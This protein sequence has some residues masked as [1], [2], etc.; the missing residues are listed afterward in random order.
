MNYENIYKHYENCFETYGDSPLGVDW[1]NKEDAVKRYEVMLNV[2]KDNNKKV[3]ILDFGCGCGHLLNYIN[4]KELNIEYSGLDIS[5]KF[6][7]YCK[8]KYISNNFYNLDILKENIS[9]LPNFDYII[10]NG[11]FTEKRDLS[12]EYMFSFFSELLKKLYTKINIGLAFNVMSPIVDFKRDDLFYLSYDKLGVF[13]KENLSR[14]Y[15][16]NNNYKLWEYT[17]YVYK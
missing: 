17:T 13:L 4:E 15:I 11:V 1:P 12:E 14:N 5:S 16:I 3:S 6:Y 9:E 10:L 8:N 2:I 7:N